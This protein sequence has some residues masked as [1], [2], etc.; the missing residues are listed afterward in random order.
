[1][2]FDYRKNP[3]FGFRISPAENENY[4]KRINLIL[5]KENAS[6][7]NK[8]KLTKRDVFCLVLDAGL[9]DWD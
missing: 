4:R 9:D 5:K 6:R 2:K 3:L 8:K 1:M 7:K